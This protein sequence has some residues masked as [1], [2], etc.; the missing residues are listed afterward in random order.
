MRHS[1]SPLSRQPNSR[2]RAH[3]LARALPAPSFWLADA[4]ILGLI[5]ALIRLL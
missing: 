2:A 5:L 4:L 1:P 3:T